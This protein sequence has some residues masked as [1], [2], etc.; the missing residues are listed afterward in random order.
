MEDPTRYQVTV[1]AR[2]AA[3]PARVYEVLADYRHGHP[4]ILPSNFRNMQVEQGGRGAGTVIRFEV[5]AFGK[6]QSFRHRVSEPEPGR[7]LVERDVDGSGVTTFTVDRGADDGEA[8]VT[9]ASTLTSR[10]GVLGAIERVMSRTFLQR[11]YR[12]ELANLD[13]FARNTALG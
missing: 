3:P 11:L 2:I 1:S 13:A 7:V 10:P 5:R 6:T 9:I 8:T 12:Q 4:H